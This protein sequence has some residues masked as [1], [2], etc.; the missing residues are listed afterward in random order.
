MIEG[1][2]PGM[3]SW[4]HAKMSLLSFKKW[5]IDSLI[6][7]RGGGGGGGGGGCR[8]MPILVDFSGC[9]SSRMIVFSSS[10]GSTRFFR[11]SIVIV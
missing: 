3:S 2:I 11:S 1:S 6:W 7:A 8:L 9:F 4:L 5:I 10:D